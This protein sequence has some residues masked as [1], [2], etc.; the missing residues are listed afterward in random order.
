MKKLIILFS[1]LLISSLSLAQDS[2]EKYKDYKACSECFDKWEKSSG[3]EGV[4]KPNIKKDNQVT[5]EAKRTFG[6]IIGVFVSAIVGVITLKI[7]NS[8]NGL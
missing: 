8:T 4:S 3:Y 1:L 5:R 7:I 6:T 2:K